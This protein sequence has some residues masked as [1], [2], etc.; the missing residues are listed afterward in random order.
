M[1]VTAAQYVHI[2]LNKVILGSLFSRN[3]SI[4]QSI[5]NASFPVN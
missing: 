2:D 1:D 4:Y 3:L 5:L